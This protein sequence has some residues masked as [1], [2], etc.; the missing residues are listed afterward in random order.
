M[1]TDSQPNCEYCKSNDWVH[2]QGAWYRCKICSRIDT[3]QTKIRTCKRCG[4]PIGKYAKP[5]TM[6]CQL[7][8]ER[9]VQT[10]E[11]VIPCSTPGC[12]NLLGKR[13]SLTRHCRQCLSEMDE[14]NVPE[15]HLWKEIAIGLICSPV[16]K[17]ELFESLQSRF[18]D[19]TEGVLGTFLIKHVR[20]GTLIRTQGRYRTP[21]GSTIVP[22]VPSPVPFFPSQ[23]LTVDLPEI[24]GGGTATK[25]VINITIGK[26]S[27]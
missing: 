9:T 7:C 4:G 26:D 1:G 10:E 13:A 14:W 22:E 2:V 11:S 25:V 16:T 8:R 23:V 19:L 24:I 3:I 21:N 6:L 17:G 18:P 12:P 5:S 20:A 15:G 27:T